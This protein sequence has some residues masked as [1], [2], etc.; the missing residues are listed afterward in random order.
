MCVH[1]QRRSDIESNREREQEDGQTGEQ[2]DAEGQVGS[3]PVAWREG[4]GGQRMKR[5]IDRIGSKR[6]GEEAVEKMPPGRSRRRGGG[7]T[8]EGLHRRGRTPIP[9]S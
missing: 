5:P 1:T 2:A 8:G 4:G 7:P 6:G 3:E 9:G